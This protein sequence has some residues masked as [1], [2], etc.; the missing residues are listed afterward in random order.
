MGLTPRQRAYWRWNLR[1]TFT[2]LM[3][4]FLLTF[5]AGYYA[6]TLNNYNFLGFPLGFYTFAQGILIAY[7]ALILIYV[8]LMNWLDRHYGVEEKS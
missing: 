2:L 4:W 7:L 5:G 8:R 1:I 3:V 6:E